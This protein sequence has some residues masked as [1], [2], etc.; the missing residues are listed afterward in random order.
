MSQKLDWKKMK[1]YRYIFVGAISRKQVTQACVLCETKSNIAYRGLWVNDAK[2]RVILYYLC[3]DCAN[4]LFHGMSITDQQSIIANVIE[5][6]IESF[7]SLP[8]PKISELQKR[9]FDVDL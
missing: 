6:K 1:N 5:R 4:E 8:H 9:G 2:E 3:E 7:L